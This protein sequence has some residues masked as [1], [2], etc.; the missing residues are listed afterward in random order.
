MGA[1]W[2]WLEGGSWLLKSRVGRSSVFL[3]PDL[4]T[5]LVNSWNQ[6]IVTNTTY[7]CIWHC[8]LV[9]IDKLSFHQTSML[10]KDCFIYMRYMACMSLR[11]SSNVNP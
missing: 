8:L 7:L 4:A 2:S 10:C 3:Y 6:R 5:A 1:T 9:D 11:N